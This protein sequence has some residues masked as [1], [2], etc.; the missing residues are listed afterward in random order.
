[1]HT[2]I[3]THIH[4]YTLIQTQTNFKYSTACSIN[5]TTRAHSSSVRLPGFISNDCIST[6]LSIAYSSG[7]VMIPDLHDI[8]GDAKAH[9]LAQLFTSNLAGSVCRSRWQVENPICH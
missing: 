3:H 1:M 7:A 5:C 6:L 8:Q 2:H 9:T 4:T